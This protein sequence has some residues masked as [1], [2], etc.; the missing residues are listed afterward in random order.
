[1]DEMSDLL[2]EM[3]VFRKI[4]KKKKVNKELFLKRIVI[5]NR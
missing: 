5:Y 2:G 4:S 1:M 3:Y